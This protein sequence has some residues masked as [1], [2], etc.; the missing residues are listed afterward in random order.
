MVTEKDLEKLRSLQ[1]II[2]EKINLEKSIQEIPKASG[3]LRG[4]SYKA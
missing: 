2:F 3:D 4:T 1:E